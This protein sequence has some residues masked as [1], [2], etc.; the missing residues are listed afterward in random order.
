LKEAAWW[1]VLEVLKPCCCGEVEEA[2]EIKDVKDKRSKKVA[3]EE[4][5]CGR[6]DKIRRF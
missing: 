1:T 4:R 2:K 6:M 3:A 5:F